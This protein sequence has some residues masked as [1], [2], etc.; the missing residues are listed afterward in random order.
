MTV[1]TDAALQELITA[2]LALVGDDGSGD[3][4]LIT[5]R[6]MTD[7]PAVRHEEIAMLVREARVVRAGESRG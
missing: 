3:V 5:R 6:A 2:V 4:E 7:H 1:A